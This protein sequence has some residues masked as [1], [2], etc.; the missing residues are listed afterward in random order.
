MEERR[1]FSRI[2]FVTDVQVEYGKHTFE[3]ELLDISLQGVLLQFKEPAPL[4]IDL[5]DTCDLH[6]V[7][8]PSEIRLQFS[9][10]LVHNKTGQFGFNF[11]SEDIETMAHLRRLIELN[12]GDE[13]K[14][15]RELP[16][17]LKH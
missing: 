8:A 3:A 9:M 13:G 4:E 1:R 12:L 17:L 7:L 2:K 16:F 15:T 6:L 5:G 14:V 11:L 10:K